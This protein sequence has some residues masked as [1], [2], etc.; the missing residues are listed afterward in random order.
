MQH[1]VKHLIQ[2][3]ERRVSPRW[4]SKHMGHR[5][6]TKLEARRTAEEQHA[7]DNVRC[8][9]AIHRGDTQQCHLPDCPNQRS[10]AAVNT[11]PQHL[12]ASTA[13]APR[14][15][16]DG[17]GWENSSGHTNIEILNAQQPLKTNIHHE[18]KMQHSDLKHDEVQII[19]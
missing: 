4:A 5:Q 11:I 16:H 14:S 1:R 15:E 7:I 17:T 10:F 18:Q 19:S 12:S 2:L 9:K 8:N 13:R 3:E 6:D